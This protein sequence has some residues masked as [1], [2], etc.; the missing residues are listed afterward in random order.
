MRAAALRTTVYSNL[1]RWVCDG[2][3][4][5]SVISA[6]FVVVSD[7]FLLCLC[8][9]WFNFFCFDLFGGG[10]VLFLW[11]SPHHRFAL[12]LFFHLL[13]FDLFFC[14]G[15][16]VS[17]LPVVVLVFLVHA[18]CFLFTC[19]SVSRVLF[20]GFGL[21]ACSAYLTGCSCSVPGFLQQV[22]LCY[23]FIHLS[24]DSND[25][26]MEVMRSVVVAMDLR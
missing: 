10:F 19:G 1:R 9:T 24:G 12:L 26:E 21:R 25:S 23:W 15:G 3:R 5:G 22:W 4:G 7:P 6:R 17:T 2:F 13:L 18:Q 11:W 8:S 16:G 14:G 20:L